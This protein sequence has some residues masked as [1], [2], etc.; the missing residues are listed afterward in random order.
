LQATALPVSVIAAGIWI[1]YCVGGGLYG[2]A[3]AAVAMLSMAASVVVI[4]PAC[5]AGIVRGRQRCYDC[6]GGREARRREGV[7]I[8]L[9]GSQRSCERMMAV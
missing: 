1:A 9:I 8:I 3:L 5:N 4:Q 7:E 6:P 2:V